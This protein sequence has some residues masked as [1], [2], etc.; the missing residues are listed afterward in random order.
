MRIASGTIH[1][2][3]FA[4]SLAYSHLLSDISRRY[5]V[6][7]E[8][9]DR[10]VQSR[11]AKCHGLLSPR[12]AA[13]SVRVSLALGEVEARLTRHLAAGA[14]HV[15]GLKEADAIEAARAESAAGHPS[16]LGYWS[17]PGEVATSIVAHCVHGIEAVAEA[18]LPS[19]VSIKVDHLGFDRTLVMEVLRVARAN[20][21]RVHFD[22]QGHDTIDPTHAL[23]EDAVM[24]GCD[25]SAT[26]QARFERSTADAERFI[27][28]RIP[29]RV[30]KGQGGDPEHPKM[31]PRCAFLKLID[32]LSGRAAHVGVATHD[33]RVAEPAL[34]RLLAD[35]TPCVLEQMRSLPRLDLLATQRGLPTQV[36]VAYGHPGLPYAVSELM[37]R[38]AMLGWIMRDLVMRR[39]LSSSS[40]QCSEEP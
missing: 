27:R 2:H 22:A 16:T 33:R 4:M 34:D 28:L 30:V 6:S 39:A 32:T 3:R 13:H 31:D 25:V 10:R 19:S 20:R 21:V 36:Y 12:T 38:P 1:S 40:A 9:L 24:Q 11:R 14:S 8:Q 5:G 7:E 17:R 37:R 15:T 26:L 29:I 23:I 18:K 35:N